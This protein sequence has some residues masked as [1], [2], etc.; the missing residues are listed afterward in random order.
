VHPTAAVAVTGGDDGTVRLWSVD[1]GKGRKCLARAKMVDKP[2]PIKNSS[3]DTGWRGTC[4][5]T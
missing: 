3:F 1:P 4:T 2:V 5:L